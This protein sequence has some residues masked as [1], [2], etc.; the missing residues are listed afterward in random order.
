MSVPSF[1]DLGKSA[2]DVFVTG[3]HYGK[4]LM[5]LTGKAGTGGNVQVDSDLR[6]YFD[7]SK[8]KQSSNNYKEN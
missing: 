7:D 8:V 3:Y 1:A 6:V 4:S 5:K 2:R